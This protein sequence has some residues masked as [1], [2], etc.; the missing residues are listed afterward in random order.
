MTEI[1]TVNSS[2]MKLHNEQL[3]QYLR[4]MDFESLSAEEAL[5]W[6][7]ATFPSG[8]AVLSTSFQAAGVAMVHMACG[9]NDE[10]FAPCHE[11]EFAQSSSDS[12][13]TVHIHR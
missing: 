13:G 4:D 11:S 1:D 5:R 12:F 3:E 2:E 7:A 6:A 10:M 9:S 8:R